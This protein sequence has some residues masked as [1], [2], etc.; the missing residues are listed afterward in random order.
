MKEQIPFAFPLRSEATFENYIT[1]R[2]AEIQRRLEDL[3]N[4]HAFQIIWLWGEQGVGCTH[5]LHA[6]CHQLTT[7]HGQVG[8]V[9]SAD[10]K[11]KS[12]S[13]TGFQAFDAVAIDDV[14]LWLARERAER[15][16]VDL[17]QALQSNAGILLLS[18]TKP[19]V[20]FDYCFNDLASRFGAAETYE[21]I[22]LCDQGKM[23][24]VQR[25]AELRGLQ[26][27]DEVARYMLTR[28]SRHLTDLLK[29][30]SNLDRHSLALNRRLTVPFVKQVLK[31]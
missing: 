27:D 13:L 17:Y 26:L 24:F 6:S 10:L 16:L 5:L 31:V 28:C 12:E 9:P 1:G 19:P 30:I 22:D 8:F 29:M 7:H 25:Q 18:S 14:H 11:L 4:A 3:S 21:V 15:N 20:Q 23:M 2:N